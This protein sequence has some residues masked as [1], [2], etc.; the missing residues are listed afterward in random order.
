M[1]PATDRLLTPDEVSTRLGITLDGL[2]R[3]RQRREGPRHLKVG[4]RVRYRPADVDAY[5]AAC[6]VGS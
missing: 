4:N 1:E 5:I 6:E 3:W 2:A